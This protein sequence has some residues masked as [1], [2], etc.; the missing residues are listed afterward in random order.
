MT[1]KFNPI[2]IKLPM[3][4]F[5]E[6]EQIIQKFILI[7]KIPRIAKATLRKKQKQKQKQKPGGISL[8]DLRQ[9]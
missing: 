6:L 7:Q 8:L 4:F 1:Y 2:S 5:T 9:Y 3:T